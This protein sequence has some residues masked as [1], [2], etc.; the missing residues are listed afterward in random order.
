MRRVP[1]SVLLALLLGVGM[2]LAYAWV[3]APHPITNA[4]PDALR[5]VF[6]DQ[7]RSLIAAAYAAT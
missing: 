5:A 6:K 3:L 1:W 4:P 7:Y 2:G